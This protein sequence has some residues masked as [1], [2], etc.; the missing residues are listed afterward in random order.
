MVW[1]TKMENA[2]ATS[3]DGNVHT[4]TLWRRGPVR[5]VDGRMP[6][7][8]RVG[9]GHV[10][11]GEGGGGQDGRGRDGPVGDHA[12]VRHAGA[13]DADREHVPGLH[14]AGGEVG[15]RVA[16]TA[17]VL[18]V[19]AERGDGVLLD[20]LAV[21]ARRI[22]AVRRCVHGVHALGE[23][24]VGT[25][26][27]VEVHRVPE[28]QHRPRGVLR[29]QL[30][31]VAE[32]VRLGRRGGLQHRDGEDHLEHI[33][34]TGEPH[35]PLVVAQD[36]GAGARCGPGWGEGGDGDRVGRGGC[37]AV[38]DVPGVDREEV[39]HDRGPGVQCGREVDPQLEADL[40]ALAEG[41]L[42]RGER[43][44]LAVGRRGPRGAVDRG[45][46]GEQVGGVP[47]LEL[48]VDGG[49]ARALRGRRR[50]TDGH[51]AGLAGARD[52][53]RG[54]LQRH[55]VGERVTGHGGETGP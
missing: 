48:L 1:P 4:M 10:L 30:H 13:V 46:P 18:E 12:E 32:Q 55:R 47:G 22:G 50:V 8:A 5:G 54:A 7:I 34:G 2:S 40:V 29:A 11:A 14:A 38:D 28:R 16:V 21:L 20:H 27:E 45:V 31:E 9:A 23:G 44:R 43:R 15:A 25:G 52:R 41:E 42:R 17:Q 19:D 53:G 33:T 24:Q 3:G 35:A 39:R 37:V 51:G 6:G 36:P 26:G 49:R